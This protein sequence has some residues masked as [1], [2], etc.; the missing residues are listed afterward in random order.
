VRVLVD[1]DNDGEEWWEWGGV[2][3]SEG[4]GRERG[5]QQVDLF[6][7]TS[8]NAKHQVLERVLRFSRRDLVRLKSSLS[9]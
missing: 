5:S 4:K 6:P 2:E 7:I 1:N 8:R 9:I 3:W